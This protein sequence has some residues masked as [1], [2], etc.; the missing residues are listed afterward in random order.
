MTCDFSD[1]AKTLTTFVRRLPEPRERAVG[2]RASAA[3]GGGRRHVGQGRRQ[4][5]VTAGNSYQ[6]RSASLALNWQITQ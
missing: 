6:G 3:A 2:R 4:A 1:T 5:P